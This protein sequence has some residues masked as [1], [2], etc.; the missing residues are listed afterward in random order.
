MWN[1]SESDEW[2]NPTSKTSGTLAYSNQVEKLLV[3]YENGYILK[4]YFRLMASKSI[5]KNPLAR[6]ANNQLQWNLESSGF[7]PNLSK[8]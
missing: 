5:F 6:P 3:K 4:L 8:Y 2:W 7:Q 1:K